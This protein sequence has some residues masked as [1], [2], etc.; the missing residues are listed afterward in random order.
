[1][2]TSQIELIHNPGNQPMSVAVFLSGSGTNFIAL[3]EEQKRLEKVGEKN[4]GSID[5]VFTNV[6]NC[7]GSRIA[8]EYG[9]PVADLSSKRYFD[10]LNKDPN[11][12]E[13]RDYYDAAV[14]SA[15]EQICSPDIIVLAGYRRR[16]G[17]LFLDRYKNRVIN[18]Y[19][20]DI[21]KDYLVKGVDS[22]VQAIR[23]GEK[24]TKCTV[25]LQKENQRFGPALLQSKPISLKGYSQNDKD[26]VN[27]KIRVEGE[28]KILPY[29]VHNLIA[30]GCLGVDKEDNVYMDE[31]K[32]ERAGLQ[33]GG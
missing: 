24:V 22:W 23:A 27:E 7:N 8:E 14:I 26:L 15:V 21:T 9:I 32:L 33:F 11:D 30:K 25:F 29:T 17:S 5:A 31:V 20:G 12:D 1:M 10:L 18:L 6:P 16:L 3:Y 13:T 2:K 28:W 19:P 4:Y